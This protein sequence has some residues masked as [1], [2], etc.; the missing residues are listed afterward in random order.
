MECDWT[1][2]N[3]FSFF[4]SV[5]LPTS[6]TAL[7]WNSEAWR[8][9][10]LSVSLPY[11]SRHIWKKKT[12]NFASPSSSSSPSLFC[13]RSL[14]LIC[15][16]CRSPDDA[17]AGA[18]IGRI[19]ASQAN[20]TLGKVSGNVSNPLMRLTHWHTVPV[21]VARHENRSRS[22]GWGWGAEEGGLTVTECARVRRDTFCCSLSGPTSK[23][24]R[25]RW[26]T[27]AVY[28]RQK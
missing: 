26:E 19:N 16:N 28:K 2:S 20:Q 21:A 1:S 24:R 13:L 15:V 12:K 22:R 10:R 4:P 27:P 5:T 14:S 8:A 17:A 25:L 3:H 18:V 7:I 23:A 11:S 9:T 6:K